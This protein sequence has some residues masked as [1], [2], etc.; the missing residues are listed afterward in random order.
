[1]RSAADPG[2]PPSLAIL[3]ELSTSD[4]L[5]TAAALL[6][7]SAVEGHSGRRQKVVDWLTERLMCPLPTLV[8]FLSQ[9]R[10]RLLSDAPAT[11]RAYG[12]AAAAAAVNVVTSTNGERGQNG[13][14]RGGGFSDVGGGHGASGSSIQVGT[15]GR[16]IRRTSNGGATG[17][18]CL[19]EIKTGTGQLYHSRKVVVATGAFFG[20]RL[21]LPGPS[22]RVP[23]TTDAN[24]RL[25]LQ[26]LTAQVVRVRLPRPVAESLAGMPSVIFKNAAYWCYILPPIEYPDGSTY[27]KLGGAPMK[28]Q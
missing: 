25:E 13:G 11:V 24:L 5:D 15:R 22:V 3:D 16:V 28:V 12:Q 10:R 9:L 21:L 26:L 19:F 20:H 23:V 18:G 6:S 8:P 1:M 17:D 14:Y 7:C 2:A 27:L 4:A